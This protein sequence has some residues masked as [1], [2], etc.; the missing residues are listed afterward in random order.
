MIDSLQITTEGDKTK[1]EDNIKAI[2]KIKLEISM[3][4]DA[5]LCMRRYL[6]NLSMV[7]LWLWK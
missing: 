3:L 1:I 7:M 4:G 5:E 6:R 2:D